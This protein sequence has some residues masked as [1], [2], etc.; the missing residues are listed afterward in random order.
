[1]GHTHHESNAFCLT[2]AGHNMWVDA[3]AHIRIGDRLGDV[4]DFL[5]EGAAQHGCMA[6]AGHAKAQS[7]HL[8][9]AAAHDNDGAFGKAGFLRQPWLLPYQWECRFQRPVGNVI[10]DTGAAGDL[11]IPCAGFQREYACCASIGRIGRD[12]AGQARQDPV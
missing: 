5:P 1:M 6:G 7:A 8:N 4:D 11:Q 2:D 9:V 3:Y 12:N 10:A